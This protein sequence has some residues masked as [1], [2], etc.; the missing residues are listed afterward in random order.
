M[1]NGRPDGGQ[2]SP[3]AGLGQP[4]A[5][6]PNTLRALFHIYTVKKKGGLDVTNLVDA[7]RSGDKR[8]TLI[9]LRDIL[10]KTIQECDSGRDM[11]SNTKRLMEVMA[12]IDALPDP[13]TKKISKH[14]RLKNKV[15]AKR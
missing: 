6:A 11:A 13:D 9:A 7:A 1:V 15:N 2:G 14:D 4:R 5:P 12:E 3:Y 8:K 10:A